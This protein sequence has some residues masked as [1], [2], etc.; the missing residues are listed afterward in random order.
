MDDTTKNENQLVTVDESQNALVAV[1][2]SENVNENLLSSIKVF[3]KDL[4][5]VTDTKN[6]KEYLTIVNHIEKKN[7]KSYHKLI[8]GF[9]VFFNNNSEQLTKGDFNDLNDP[10]I[11]F[12]SNNDSFSF[13]F[14]KIFED[15]NDADKEVIKEHLNHIWN[16]LDDSNKSVEE[17]YIEKIF[18]SLKSKFVP[19]LDK[20]DQIAVIKD[21]VLKES[22]FVDFQNQNL[23][24]PILLKV[25]CKKVREIIGS[26]DQ[27]NFL[28]IVDVIE[29]IDLNDFNMAQFMN[30]VSKIGL[31]SYSDGDSILNNI[32]SEL[33]GLIKM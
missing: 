21:L 17:L 3:M 13:N 10:N 25:L 9:K 33:L 23:N 29:D 4:S 2:E 28:H 5:N 22:F 20:E 24:I 31:L 11:C 26:N 1:D 12:V 14:Q 6:F 15:A 18:T 27:S 19:E 30:I 16:I 8:N 32:L 7:V